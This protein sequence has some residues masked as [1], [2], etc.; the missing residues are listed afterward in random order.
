VTAAAPEWC[1]GIVAGGAREEEDS[2]D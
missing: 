2:D 1:G